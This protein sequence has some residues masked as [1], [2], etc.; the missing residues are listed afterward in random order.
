MA[1]ITCNGEQYHVSG[2]ITLQT[3]SQI[4]RDNGISKFSI[5]SANGNSLSASNFPYDGGDIVIKKANSAASNVFT[6]DEANTFDTKK[7]SSGFDAAE[8]AMKKWS[9]LDT[10]KI[11][12]QDLTPNVHAIK[13]SNG[14]AY[15]VEVSDFNMDTLKVD[16]GYLKGTNEIIAKIDQF[17]I[18]ISVPNSEHSITLFDPD[19]IVSDVKDGVLSI[20]V[21]FEANPDFVLKPLFSIKPKK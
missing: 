3:V 12:K 5:Y 13:Y 6:S 18:K 9:V 11:K 2:Q 8:I 20:F 1:T 10:S 17:Q 7:F 21:P 19:K 4:A 14:I 15:L 16:V